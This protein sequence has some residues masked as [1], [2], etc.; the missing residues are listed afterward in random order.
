[1][2]P[3]FRTFRGLPFQGISGI[4]PIR[5]SWTQ[6]SDRRFDVLA[7]E[8][9]LSTI[10]DRQPLLTS[11]QPF[12]HPLNRPLRLFEVVEEGLL[13]IGQHRAESCSGWLPRRPVS[14]TSEPVRAA[15]CGGTP[16]QGRRYPTP[17]LPRG[18]PHR[19]SS[20]GFLFIRSKTSA[21]AILIESPRMAR[22]NSRAAWS[23]RLMPA[24]PFCPF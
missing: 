10:L 14:A 1:M 6:V 20:L 19:E 21:W 13:L 18:Q 3:Q 11:S 22:W 23:A 17:W 12:G 8:S 9:E 2:P 7:L 16:V 15:S 5:K 4:K 24:I